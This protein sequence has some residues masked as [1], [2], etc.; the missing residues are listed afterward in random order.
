MC[1]SNRAD[2]FSPG[3]LQGGSLHLLSKTDVCFLVHL[4]V[5]FSKSMLVD[6]LHERKE[7]GKFMLEK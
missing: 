6:S 4:G 2:T 3:T 5:I 1:S 7:E